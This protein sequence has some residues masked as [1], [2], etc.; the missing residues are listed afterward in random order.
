MSTGKL[1]VIIPTRNR[2]DVLRKTLEAYCSQSAQ[3]EI[4]EIFVVDDGSSDGSDSVVAQSNEGS[5]VPIRYLRQDHRGAAAARNLAI[6]AA[7]GDLLLFTDD[8]VVPSATLVE[9]HSQWHLQNPDPCVAA[10]GKITW[11]PD[12]H[13]TPFM[14]WLIWAGPLLNLRECARGKELGFEF[15]YTGNLSLK[16]EFLRK[17]GIFDEDFG[18]YGYEDLEL[19]YRL[20]RKGLRLLYNPH[21][22]GYHYKH[23]SFADACR[24]AQL[25]AAA[26]KV[27]RTKEAGV[28]FAEIV[29]RRRGS[30]KYRVQKFLVSWLA[31]ALAPL[32]LF[33]DT[34]I[35]LPWTVYRALYHYYCAQKGKPAVAANRNSERGS[36]NG[37][38]AKT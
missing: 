6:R 22:V 27:F 2:K 37:S 18:G 8:D 28:C 3:E 29:A 14:N 19:G 16:A 21:A 33:L 5:P 35:P 24:R 26:D 34:Q 36:G 9:E 11:H 1:S 23:I 30:L 7:R 20:I 15:F 13:P 31:P 4:L 12:V 25:V 17:N 10:V 32:K 38:L